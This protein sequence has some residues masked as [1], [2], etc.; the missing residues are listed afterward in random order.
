[1]RRL[2]QTLRM[3]TIIE[4]VSKLPQCV[5]GKSAAK[6]CDYGRCGDCC[7]GCPR[8]PSED[9]CDICEQPMHECDCEECGEYD[10]YRKVPYDCEYNCARCG[11]MWLLW[12]ECGMQE[13]RFWFIRMM[14]RRANGGGDRGHILHRERHITTCDCCIGIDVRLVG[15]R[16]QALPHD[17]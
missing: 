6:D 4:G 12:V 8:H 13:D 15:V 3:P 16:L 9:C 1:M 10:C 11:R 5:C 17:L 7:D 14:G 2:S